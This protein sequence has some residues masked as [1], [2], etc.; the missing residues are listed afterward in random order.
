MKKTIFAMFI[1]SL[2]IFTNLVQ[3]NADSFIT[4]EQFE[5]WS[6]D[7]T[8]VFRWTPDPNF[9]AAHAR[10]YRDSELLYRM[11]NL[12]IMG[13]SANN[14]FFS[15]N[16]RHIT[17][18]PT[19]GF[20]VAIKFYT[21]GELAKTHY[22]SDLVRDMNRVGRSVTMS[23]W[24]G[25]FPQTRVFSE[26][27]AEYDTMRIITVERIV[28]ELDLTSGEILGY[29]NYDSV[30]VTRD[31]T[32]KING[33]EIEF[34]DQLPMIQNDRILVPVRNVFETLGFRVEWHEDMQTVFLYEA[35]DAFHIEIQIGMPSFLVVRPGSEVTYSNASVH[36][37][38]IPAQIIGARTLLPLRA[39][40]EVVGYQLDWDGARSMV[41]ISYG[42]A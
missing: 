13:V 33:Y 37:L 31:I 4:P 27:I 11:D 22:I 40:L 32:V 30:P 1:C 36:M 28:Y 6:D 10:V 25:V 21:D 39:V 7:E 16:F 19:T 42:G 2:F 8:M 24:R 23:F 38:D 34:L 17:F 41:L 20:Y 5:V 15:Q 29:W 12:P 9:R 35:D 14:F 26:H 18:F 3:V